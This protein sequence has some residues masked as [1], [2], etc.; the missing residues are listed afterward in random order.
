[1][2]GQGGIERRQMRNHEAAKT[3]EFARSVVSRATFVLY[4]PVESEQAYSRRVRVDLDLESSVLAGLDRRAMRKAQRLQALAERRDVGRERTPKIS[5]VTTRVKAAE[6]AIQFA[7]RRTNT[8]R[9]ADDQGSVYRRHGASGAGFGLDPIQDLIHR[10]QPSDVSQ[11]KI[12]ALPNDGCQTAGLS[13]PTQVYPNE[14]VHDRR[15]SST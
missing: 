4:D 11:T 15:T 1:M 2:E 6:V 13:I 7:L 9:I 5:G 12:G 3:A 14:C 8:G 10:L